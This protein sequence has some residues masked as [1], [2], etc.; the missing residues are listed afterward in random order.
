MSYGNLSFLGIYLA[1]HTLLQNDKYNQSSYTLW[2]VR[3]IVVVKAFIIVNWDLSSLYN[4][5]GPWIPSLTKH[6]AKNDIVGKYNAV[7]WS[8]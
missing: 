7:H 6:Q 3:H 5:T 1:N 4:I 8:S 2:V